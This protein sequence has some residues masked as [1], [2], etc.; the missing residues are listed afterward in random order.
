MEEKCVTT[1]YLW[2]QSWG[3]EKHRENNVP[4]S[5]LII[6]RILIEIYEMPKLFAFRSESCLEI[7]SKM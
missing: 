2:L 1:F 5:V 7:T 6:G 3:Q 4:L